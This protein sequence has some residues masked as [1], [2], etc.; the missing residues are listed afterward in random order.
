MHGKNRGAFM[1]FGHASIYMGLL[2]ACLGLQACDQGGRADPVPEVEKKL[3]KVKCEQG[4]DLNQEIA[5]RF[6]LLKVEK[7]A[8]IRTTI[9]ENSRP[10]VMDLIRRG[11]LTLIDEKGINDAIE[12]HSK[13]DHVSKMSFVKDCQN[14]A[15]TIVVADLALVGVVQITQMGL[16]YIELKMNEDLIRI[17]KVMPDKKKEPTKYA[18]AV[19][20]D[21]KGKNIIK[22]KV[23]SVKGTSVLESDSG[24]LSDL[25]VIP[26]GVAILSSLTELA[27]KVEEGG[28][29]DKAKAVIGKVKAQLAQKARESG[30]Q[31]DYKSLPDVQLKA[32]EVKLLN[33]ILKALEGATS[34]A[35]EEQGPPIILKDEDQPS[36]T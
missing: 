30:G 13:T 16:D 25:D 5:R 14:L 31:I 10:E 21:K 24:I 4:F 35:Q 28:L 1:S 29:S 22:I 23:S 32:E 7:K 19:E 6:S 15:G 18:E 11:G 26:M 2:V 36:A 12:D 20:N 3:L 27:D 9:I 8:S 17:E 33:E 34:A